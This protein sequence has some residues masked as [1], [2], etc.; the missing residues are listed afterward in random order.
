VSPLLSTAILLRII[1]TPAKPADESKII[2]DRGTGE[3][4]RLFARYDRGKEGSRLPHARGAEL[5]GV[6]AI[7]RRP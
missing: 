5:A 4:F 3:S 7:W 1:L 2:F 6:R